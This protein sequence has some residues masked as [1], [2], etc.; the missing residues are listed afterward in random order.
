MG[1]AHASKSDHHDFFFF[2]LLDFY[3]L[4]IVVFFPYILFFNNSLFHISFR[5]DFSAHLELSNRVD[6]QRLRR[7]HRLQQRLKHPPHHL[8]V[9]PAVQQHRAGKGLQNIAQ[10]LGGRVVRQAKGVYCPSRSLE[11]NCVCG[12]LKRKCM[13]SWNRFR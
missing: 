12:H 9:Q 13:G 8:V 6:G 11:L 5:L 10:N 4:F 7:D 1:T 2:S 3:V